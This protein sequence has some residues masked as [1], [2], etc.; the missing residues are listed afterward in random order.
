MTAHLRLSRR[1]RTFAVLVSGTLAGTMFGPGVAEAARRVIADD[2]SCVTPCVQDS[3]ISGVAASKVAGK[4]DGADTL[5][6]LDSDAFARV[7]WAGTVLVPL[8]ALNPHGDCTSLWIT[9]PIPVESGDQILVQ[10][11]T[12][13]KL[14]VTAT[15]ETNGSVFVTGCNFTTSLEG[16]YGEYSFIVLRNF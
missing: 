10:P 13:D 5:D 6:G 16:A 11:P 1:T 12:G 8:R 15:T 4:V 14:V 2:V 7:A 9:L 3:E